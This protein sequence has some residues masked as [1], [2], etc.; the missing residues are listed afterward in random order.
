MVNSLTVAKAGLLAFVLS[1]AAGCSPSAAPAASPTPPSIL[2]VGHGEAHAKPDVAT[3]NLGVEERSPTMAEAMQRNAAQMAQ[4]IA[5]LKGAGVAEKDIQT[6]NINVHFE[7]DVPPYPY[8]PPPPYGAVSEPAP[9]PAVAPAPAGGSKT[10]KPPQPP[11]A[12]AVVVSP[13]PAPAPRAAPAGRFVVSNNVK[14]CVRDIA[15]VGAVIDAAAGAGSNN[16]WGVSFELEKKEGVEAELRQK[17][18]A[19]AKSRAEALAR[20]SGVE[21]GPVISVSEV[22]SGQGVMPPMPMPISYAAEKGGSSTPVEAGQMTFNG[23]V[24]VVYAIKR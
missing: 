19:D 18:V 20:L 21:L 3:I 10:M 12:P 8:P 13:A 24:Q 15:R 5:A 9:A 16:M 2:V 4:L 23:Q 1:C 14:I 22:V 11:K 7:R 17:S 6:S